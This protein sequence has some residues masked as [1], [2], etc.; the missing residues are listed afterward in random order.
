MPATQIAQNLAFINWTVLTGLALGTYAAV[1]L[2]RRRAMATRGYL[3]FATACAVAFGVL[4]WLSDGALPATLGASP[5]VTDPA[6]G[7]P[8]R[9]ALIAFCGL[10]V[11]ALVARRARPG[12]AP[13]LELSAFVVGALTI[14]AGALAG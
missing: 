7:V 14:G 5:V 13:A 6:W 4:A 9:T 8:R 1:V 10:A 3:G 2:L 11:A 12:A